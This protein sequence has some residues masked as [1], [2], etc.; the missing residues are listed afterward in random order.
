MLDALAFLAIWFAGVGVGVLLHEPA[1][2]VAWRVC[3]RDATLVSLRAVER[4][5]KQ[6]DGVDAL[7]AA[8]PA[9]S[10]LA[11]VIAAVATGLLVLLPVAVG[12]VIGTDRQDPAVIRAGLS[13]GR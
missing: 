6:P 13:A 7:A 11:I 10:A 4:P 3:G 8:A 2:Y 5:A 9:L 12:L 1:H